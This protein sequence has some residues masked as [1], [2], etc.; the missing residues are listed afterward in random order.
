MKKFVLKKKKARVP[1]VV[2]Q[3]VLNHAMLNAA[4]PILAKS[5]ASGELS[6]LECSGIET[7][8]NT[9]NLNPK[10]RAFLIGKIKSAQFQSARQKLVQK[11]RM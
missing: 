1:I 11:L 8:L 10:N 5:V 2:D 4:K 7:E 6:I 9:G 3:Q